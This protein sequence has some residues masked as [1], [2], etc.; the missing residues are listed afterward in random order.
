VDG[1]N[2]RA[3]EG[4]HLFFAGEKI[5]SGDT[6][7]APK[8]EDIEFEDHWQVIPLESLVRMKLIAHRRIDRVH[9]RDLIEVGLIDT[10][11]PAKCPAPLNERLQALLDDPD[12]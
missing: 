4:I 1:P 6:I 8:V 3:S 11:W 5:K 2:G 7:E 10:T 9:L 12:G